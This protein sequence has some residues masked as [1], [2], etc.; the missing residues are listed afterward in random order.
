MHVCTHTSSAARVPGQLMG[1]CVTSQVLNGLTF[2]KHHPKSTIVW[3]WNGTKCPFKSSQNDRVQNDRWPAS[4][5]SP[6]ALGHWSLR[7]SSGDFSSHR[8]SIMLSSMHSC[9]HISFCFWRLA[10]NEGWWRGF[11]SDKGPRMCSS[12]CPEGAEMLNSVLTIRWETII[13]ASKVSC[14]S[15]ANS[16][17]SWAGSDFS[18]HLGHK[19]ITSVLSETLF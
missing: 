7:K 12:K 1:A 14:G 13:S 9:R 17:K 18:S 3:W 15:A 2:S 19:R 10:W 5:I 8:N 4:Q 16:E 11:F 6:E